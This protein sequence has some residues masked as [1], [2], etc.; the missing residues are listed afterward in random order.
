[1]NQVPQRTR[2]IEL[3][4][5]L[6]SRTSMFAPAP[7]SWC[8]EFF[9]SGSDFSR[10]IPNPAFVGLPVRSLI[11]EDTFHPPEEILQIVQTYK[12]SI[13][14]I[15][16]SMG[17][18]PP[19]DLQ[20]DFKFFQKLFS[21]LFK[22]FPADQ[23]KTLKLNRHPFEYNKSEPYLV[24]AFSNVVQR[25]ARS[26]VDL[27]LVIPDKLVNAWYESKELIDPALERLIEGKSLKHLHIDLRGSK[28]IQ[29]FI[30]G[31]T[32][33]E[34][35]K[36]AS[37]GLN[38]EDFSELSGALENNKN[39]TNLDV[40]RCSLSKE[41]RYRHFFNML[42]RN[43]SI[44]FLRASFYGENEKFLLESLSLNKGIV[45]F[46]MKQQFL[47]MD[48]FEQF[49]KYVSDSASLQMLELIPWKEKVRVPDDV[50]RLVSA[51]RRRNSIKHIKV[52]H[53]FLN[54]LS[55][56]HEILEVL[57]SMS[58]SSLVFAVRS[59]AE[60]RVMFGDFSVLLKG[61]LMRTL[62]C[63]ESNQFIAGVNLHDLFKCIQEYG[64]LEELMLNNPDSPENVVEFIEAICRYEKSSLRVL[65]IS[66]VMLDDSES[67][68]VAD[69][70]ILQTCQLREFTSYDMEMNLSQISKVVLQSESLKLFTVEHD[71]SS[72]NINKLFCS[73]EC[74]LFEGMMHDPSVS[75]WKKVAF[76]ERM[77]DELC[78][79]LS[80][81]QVAR[82]ELFEG[83]I[84][85]FI[86]PMCLSESGDLYTFM[87]RHLK[88]L[89]NEP[90]ELQKWIL[91]DQ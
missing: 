69:A 53:G 51:L 20:W 86:L 62:T 5:K 32:S 47:T 80:S 70:L 35:L 31:C 73:K 59:P 75:K 34:S 8:P 61:S 17:D 30:E 18:P 7:D 46:T 41:P 4:H 74:M 19:K 38:P 6:F 57:S 88:G 78:K 9:F 82:R 10:Q 28:M 42:E 45:S 40:D 3:L 12:D 16:M 77:V 66:N 21:I 37:L 25:H 44:R 26:L 83:N 33:L 87:V 23:L 72:E 50:S 52:F 90:K 48:I 1:L 2:A 81:K 85:K 49:C 60:S 27:E 79:F 65:R 56:A 13:E 24:Y 36:I 14:H 63:L 22:D 29:R 64:V 58:L 84:I 39:I 76:W 89:C 68:A 91:S 55:N 71:K 15:T 67:D 54:R 43:E 11:L